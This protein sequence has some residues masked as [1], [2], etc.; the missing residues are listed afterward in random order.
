MMEIGVRVTFGGEFGEEYENLVTV[1]NN[2]LE[3]GITSCQLS[4]WDEEHISD[5]LWTMAVKVLGRVGLSMFCIS[6]DVAKK[7]T[8]IHW[9]K[10]LSLQSLILR[11]KSVISL[12]YKFLYNV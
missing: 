12:M 2:V 8:C 6:I 11:I 3:L 10:T 4:V 1:F 5:D 9:L 7:R